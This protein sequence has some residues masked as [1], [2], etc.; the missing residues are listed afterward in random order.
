VNVNTEEVQDSAGKRHGK[1]NNT[2]RTVSNIL[3][4]LNVKELYNLRVCVVGMLKFRKKLHTYVT[5]AEL[6][7]QV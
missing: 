6:T 7:E 3:S 4:P 5:V 1:R 2:W